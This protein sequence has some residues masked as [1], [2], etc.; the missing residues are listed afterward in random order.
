MDINNR[1]CTKGTLAPLW[2]A[3]INSVDGA[4][5]THAGMDKSVGRGSIHFV[6]VYNSPGA[7]TLGGRADYV[8]VDY[9]AGNRFDVHV[10]QN[11]GGGATKPKGT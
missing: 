11:K 9:I 1:G 4:G 3:G 8:W 7:F 2:R 6:N 5:P 10:W